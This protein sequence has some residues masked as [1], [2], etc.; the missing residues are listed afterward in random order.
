MMP[1]DSG[2]APVL[3]RYGVHKQTASKSH[4]EQA[5]E[6]IDLLGFAVVD[7]G[8]SP[9]HLAELCAVFD[10]VLAER[11]AAHGGRTELGKIDEH[12]TIRLPLA[13]DPLFLDLALNA[14]V[15][16][17]CRHLMGDYIVLHA[18]NGIVN[19]PNAERYHEG[20]YHRDLPYQHFVSSH[21]LMV[22]ALFC[23]DPF[24][25]ENGATYLLP[26]SHKVEAFPSDAIVSACQKQICAPAGCFII[27]NS[28]VFHRGGVNTTARAR[29]AVNQPYAMPFIRQQINLP[30][31]LGPDYSADAEIRKLLGYNLQTATSIAAYYESRRAKRCLLAASDAS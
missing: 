12:N 2:A 31:V 16:A 11:E 5:V 26:A 25:A 8:Y 4:I 21:P 18:Q 30:V 13:S 20:A 27:M 19:P 1:P 23:L 14:T 22:S 3:P 7:A 9:E 24:T 6:M 17:I 15:L 10:R 29:R 28:M